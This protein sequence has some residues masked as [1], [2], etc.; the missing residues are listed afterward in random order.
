MLNE[1][2]LNIYNYIKERIEEG[3]PPT[4]REICTDLN[5]KST[6][7]VH[8]YISILTEIGYLEKIDNQNRAIKLKGYNS[9]LF[10]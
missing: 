9:R 7:T 4:I 10:P 3:I 1:M 2:A 8:K 6:S 5:I